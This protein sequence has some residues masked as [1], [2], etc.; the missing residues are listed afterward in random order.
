MREGSEDG[1][2]G[3]LGG[4]ERERR[5]QRKRVSVHEKERRMRVLRGPR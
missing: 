4:E 3:R 1:E 5:G 2:Y